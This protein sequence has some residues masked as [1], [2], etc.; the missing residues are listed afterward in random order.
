[1]SQLGW[2]L[3]ARHIMGATVVHKHHLAKISS[4][5]H[6]CVAMRSPSLSWPCLFPN[7]WG[8]LWW[9][10]DSVCWGSNGSRCSHSR[11]RQHVFATASA[12]VY[13]ASSPYEEDAGVVLCH[14]W[15]KCLLTPMLGKRRDAHPQ[16]QTAVE[17]VRMP[18]LFPEHC[19]VVMVHVL[20]RDTGQIVQGNQGTRACS[21]YELQ[22]QCKQAFCLLYNRVPIHNGVFEHSTQTQ[23]LI[24]SAGK[25]T[26]SLLPR[27]LS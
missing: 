8:F 5:R 14:A 19:S 16:L 26:R 13:L 27:L 7:M 10:S 9:D 15:G 6:L 25:H 20:L 24:M 17:T 12:L 2:Q 4:N 22:R 21:R 18:G 23:G 3:R 1:M 11:S